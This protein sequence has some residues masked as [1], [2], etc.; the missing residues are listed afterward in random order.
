MRRLP[1]L[2][3]GILLLAGCGRSDPALIPQSNAQA[4]QQSA[5]KI[6]SACDDQDRGA[7]HD[8][9]RNVRHEIDEL[10]STVDAGLVTNLKQWV[11]HISDRISQDCQ[12]EATPTPTPSATSTAT[13]TS[14]PTASPTST[15]TATR[16]AT[17]TPSPTATATATST[18]TSTPAADDGGTGGTQAESD[19]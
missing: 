16:T 12:A 2:V 11:N 17:A 5:D 19:G 14:T 6:Q 13:E 8:A 9:V 10:P 15:P 1:L 4:L 7:A 18:A 3:L